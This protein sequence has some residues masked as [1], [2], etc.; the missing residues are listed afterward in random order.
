MPLTR[1][2]FEAIAKQ[3]ADLKNSYADID[4][5]TFEA[6]VEAVGRGLR[7]TNPMFSTQRFFDAA[8][9]ERPIR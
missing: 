9:K 5:V 2:D 1:K 3:L 4:T 8:T 7:T 6:A